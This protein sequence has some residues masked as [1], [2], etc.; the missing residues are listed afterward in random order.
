[1]E[2]WWRCVVIVGGGVDVVVSLGDLCLMVSRRQ[3]ARP[4]VEE[5]FFDQRIL[6]PP[7]ESAS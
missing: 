7:V 3:F 4:A 6:I 2:A 5:S 1:M